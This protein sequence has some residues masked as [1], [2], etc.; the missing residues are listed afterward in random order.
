MTEENTWF[1]EGREKCRLCQGI[2]NRKAKYRREMRKAG[3]SEIEIAAWIAEQDWSPPD[4]P[5]QRRK[6]SIPSTSS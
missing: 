3:F 6:L 4:R 5:R 1:T 2:A